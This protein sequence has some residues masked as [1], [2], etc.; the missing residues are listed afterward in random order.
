MKIHVQLT[1]GYIFSLVCLLLG[2][3][4]LIYGLNAY[5]RYKNK[6][7]LADLKSDTYSA[8]EAVYGN[9]T[10]YAVAQY[11]ALGK[12]G[13]TGCAE[14]LVSFWGDDCEV[15]TV[16]IADGHFIRILVK[17]QDDLELLKSFTSG[18]GGEVYFEGE[19]VHSTS[20]LNGPW[21]EQVEAFRN[22]D[23]EEIVD[24][25]Y[26]I[27]EADYTARIQRINDGA[28]LIAL[29]LFVFW[30]SGG[31]KNMIYYIKA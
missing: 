2:M 20:E 22:K 4:C 5:S 31:V 30:Y 19:I 12:E 18:C 17:D 15:Y 13:S 11:E 3:S 9:I 14:T 23:I 8:G 29:S 21:Y 28:V 6:I 1:K 25:E 24:P 16:P 10:S 7:L 26:V 27:K